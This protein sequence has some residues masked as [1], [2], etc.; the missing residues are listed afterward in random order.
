MQGFRLATTGVCKHLMSLCESARQYF[1]L[2]HKMLSYGIAPFGPTLCACWVLAA[3]WSCATSSSWGLLHS[4]SLA[5]HRV[6]QF[7]TS[8]EYR[9]QSQS[10]ALDLKSRLIPSLS[11]IT[12][13]YHFLFFLS[14]EYHFT[15]FSHQPFPCILRGFL[16]HAVTTPLLYGTCVH[17]FG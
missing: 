16:V 6:K 10:R 3:Q 13:E 17:V 4:H 2:L 15:L 9:S 12:I 5:W 1:Q 14:F 7:S 11:D 8:L